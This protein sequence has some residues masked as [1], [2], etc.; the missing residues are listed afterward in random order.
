[1]RKAFI[2][3]V[4]S[5]MLAA[6]AVSA[7]ATGVKVAYINMQQ[8]FQV[9]P[10]R[11]EAAN[12]LEKEKASMQVE[13]KAMQDSMAKEVEA[14]DKDQATMTDAVKKT[15]TQALQARQTRYQERAQKM[16]QTA[17]ERE[18]DLLAP[19][20]ELMQ[21]ALEDFRA[22]GGYTVIFDIAQAGIVAIDK[23]LDQTDKVMTRLAKMP[24]PKAAAAASSTAPKTPVGPV[25]NP[26][27]AKKPPTGPPTR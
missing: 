22:E 2:L 27:G 13:F 25:A 9:A 26:A 6:P 1:M 20:Q 12:I 4:C 7:Q 19:I 24:A 21:K 16:E 11:T 10:G 8:L 5:L 23:N 15:R 3:G 18:Q 17:Q 14:F